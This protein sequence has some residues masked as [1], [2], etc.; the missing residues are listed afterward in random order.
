MK[1]Q[2]F[3]PNAISKAI[4][5]LFNGEL[6]DSESFQT[7]YILQIKT[8]FKQMNTTE[9]VSLIFPITKQLFNYEL[10]DIFKD[11]KA[12]LTI[13]SISIPFAIAYASFARVDPISAL[14]SASIP[15]IIY[16][17]IGTSAEVS[18]GPEAL[19]SIMVGLGVQ[20]ELRLG[21]EQS[22]EVIASTLALMC[23]LISILF[24]IFQTGFIADVLSGY[25]FLGFTL[26]VSN[27]IMVRQLPSLFGLPLENSWPDGEASQSAASLLI[28]YCKYLDKLSVGTTI[29]G[30][31]S[32]LFLVGMRWI[33]KKYKSRFPYLFYIPQVVHLVFFTIV[34][35]YSFD[36]KSKGISTLNF[37]KGKLYTP[38]VPRL[39]FAFVNRNLFLCTTI[40]LFGFFQTV[41][42]V[43]DFGMKK[44]YF[45]SGTRLPNC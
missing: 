6:M 17:L 29:L 39:E 38:S 37:I 11:C 45:P 32:I 23:G 18:F 12:A 40:V 44:H 26:G 36:F 25:L 14:I 16:S 41:S 31:V 24:A 19:V 35:S 9:I 42:V 28:Y 10:M 15:G 5:Q 8:Y 1:K 43:R 3:S 2:K 33:K 13:T 4:E 22:P 7:P 20:N 30:L 34:F 21:S 27:L